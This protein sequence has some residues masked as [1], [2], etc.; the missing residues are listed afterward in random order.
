MTRNTHV[1]YESSISSGLKVMAKVKVF[2]QTSRSL[3][4]KLRYHVK[5]IV[6]RNTRVQYESPISSVKK[7]M[8]K[9][10]VFK[11]KSNLKVKVTRS[12]IMVPG[13]RSCDKEYTC[14]I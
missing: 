4:Q 14:A 10:K 3:G 2:R 12:K 13:E 11:S 6:T 8:A 5:G 1:Q 7:V 9:V